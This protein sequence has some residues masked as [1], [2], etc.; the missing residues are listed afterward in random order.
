[1]NQEFKV[2]RHKLKYYISW[3]EYLY[4]SQ[5]LKATL[6][7][8]QYGNESGDYWIRSLYLDTPYNKDY[9]EKMIG[10]LNRKKIRLRIY[11]VQTDQV[12]LEI[13]N[14]YNQYMLK[15]SLVINKEEALHL[16]EGKINFLLTNRNTTAMKLYYLMHEDYYRPK[17]IVDYER[18]AYTCPMYSIRIT[19]DKNVRCSHDCHNFF[20]SNLPTVGVLEQGQVI[21]EI[22]YD[23]MLPKWIRK[24]LS[25]VIG[26]RSSISKYCLARAIIS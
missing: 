20:N 21:L 15:E 18:E 1:M 12:K 10:S 3:G 24:A 17:V 6:N 13:K 2:Y 26:N 11:D 9:D 23:Q 14:R 8:D 19:F 25:S 7:Q 5:L 16:M 4:L 22:K